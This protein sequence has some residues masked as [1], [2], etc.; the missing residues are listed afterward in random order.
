MAQATAPVL[1]STIGS[2]LA[3]PRPGSGSRGRPGQWSWAAPLDQGRGERP[4][5]RINATDPLTV[6]LAAERLQEAAAATWHGPELIISM[7][8]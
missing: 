2:L 6:L 3:G 1:D 8:E 7:C 5:T 4:S